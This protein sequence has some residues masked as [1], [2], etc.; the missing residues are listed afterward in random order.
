MI[1]LYELHIRCKCPVNNGEDEYKLSLESAHMIEV[2]TILAAVTQ[3]TTA[4]VYQE[5]LTEGLAEKLNAAIITV[6]YHS[7]VKTTCRAG[8]VSE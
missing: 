8:I 4:P 3:L 6:G 1:V 7:G 2:E 5:A